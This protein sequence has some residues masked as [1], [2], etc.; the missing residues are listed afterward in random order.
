MDHS[1]FQFFI[2]ILNCCLV[3]EK[4]FFFELVT[5]EQRV[6]P[7]ECCRFSPTSESSETVCSFPRNPHRRSSNGPDRIS[8]DY[9]VTCPASSRAEP[10]PW[11]RTTWP[12]ALSGLDG[13]SDTTSTA[14]GL[15]D[16]RWPG[17][18]FNGSVV[19]QLELEQW[20]WRHRHSF[21][22]TLTTSSEIHCRG[23]PDYR[24]GTRTL[25]RS[26]R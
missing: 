25:T 20:H 16:R 7:F 12:A 26:S 4:L 15:L 14:G 1:R 19:T 3:D 6:S 17:F 24:D 10:L 2:A 9:G 8:S 22:V 23:G 21:F 13:P 18:K 11:G 5:E